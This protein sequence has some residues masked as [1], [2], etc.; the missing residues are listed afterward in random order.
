M[1]DLSMI[2]KLTLNRK[3]YIELRGGIILPISTIGY[4]KKQDIL[5][6]IKK[7]QKFPVKSDSP[8]RE[9]ITAMKSFGYDTTP[10]N[11]VVRRIDKQSKQYVDFQKDLTRSGLFLDIATNV[12]LTYPIGELQLWEHLGLTSVTDYWGLVGWL[13]DREFEQSDIKMMSEKNKLII[14]SESKSYEDWEKMANGE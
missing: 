3:G 7:D 1:K 13:H 9:E 5:R 14:N 11:L 4:S 2:D 12:D 6:E 10:T 8:N